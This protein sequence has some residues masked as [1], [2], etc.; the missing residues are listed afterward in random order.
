MWARIVEVM[1]A[2]F[3]A[4]SSFIFPNSASLW[5]IDIC[6]S[7]WIWTCSFASFYPPLRKLHLLNLLP[8]AFLLGVSFFM[9]DPP[10]PP[11]YQN[12]VVIA[13][14]LLLFVIIPSNAGKPP[15]AWTRYTKK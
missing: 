6:T 14:L 15:D 3:L 2:A 4:I 11:P 7:L 1:L 10:P 12:Y 5:I 8:I 9:P 13:L